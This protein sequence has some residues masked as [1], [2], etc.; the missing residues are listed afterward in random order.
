MK[1][2]R[3]GA[4]GAERPGLLDKQGRV[5]DLSGVSDDITP[6]VLDPG[7]L[8]DLARLHFEDLPVAP[9]PNR[10]GVPIASVSKLVCI[11]LN[12]K[13]HAKEANLPIPQEPI[14]FL[15]AVSALSGPNDDVVLPRGSKKGDWE[16]EL[17]IVIG[18]QATYVSESEAL[19][20]VAGYT[21]V[22]DVSERAYQIERGGQWTKGKSFDTFAPVG[23]WLVTKDEIPQPQSLGIWLDVNCERRQTG[24]TNDMIFSVERLVS[25]LSE[26]MTLMPGD[27]VCTG[28]PAGV[29][30]GMNPPQFLCPGDTMRLGVDGLGEQQQRVLAYDPLV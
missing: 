11:G 19:E 24:N 13:D 21:I 14:I 3:H 12:Y 10:L 16:V 6:E 15:K 27:I 7:K 20:Y 23:P 25:Y 26:F 28:T 30:L 8:A 5:R 18:K 4:K 29:G 2:V 9:M 17:G 22:N 1:L